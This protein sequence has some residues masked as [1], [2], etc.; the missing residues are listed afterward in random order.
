MIQFILLCLGIGLILAGIALVWA[1]RAYRKRMREPEL[2]LWSGGI[3][4]LV[5]ILLILIVVFWR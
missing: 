1:G 5:G 2:V 4:I 3:A